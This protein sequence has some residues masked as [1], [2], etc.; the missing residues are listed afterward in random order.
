MAK[1]RMIV[2]CPPGFQLGPDD[3]DGSI[4]LLTAEDRAEIL[5]LLARRRREDA[6]QDKVV[7]REAAPRPRRRPASKS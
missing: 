1:G 2:E 5:E 4:D 6:R 7:P 3:I